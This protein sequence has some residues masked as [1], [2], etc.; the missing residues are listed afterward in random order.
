M[1]KKIVY[2]GKAFEVFAEMKK[3]AERCKGMTVDQYL[4]LLRLENAVEK[5]I[6]K[7]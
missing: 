4:R 6:T 5:Q 3:E 7:Q 2:A 1:D